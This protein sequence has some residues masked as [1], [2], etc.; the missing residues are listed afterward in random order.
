MYDMTQYILNGQKQVNADGLLSFLTPLPAFTNTL[1]PLDYPVIA[2][3]YAH[4][5]LTASGRVF[6]RETQ[7]EYLL[8]RAT[9]EITRA[10]PSKQFHATSLLVATWSKIGY[11]S[12][13]NQGADK[14]GTN[15]LYFTNH[16]DDFKHHFYTQYFF[17]FS[18]PQYRCTQ[19]NTFQ[20]VIASNDS[21]SF[22]E[23][24][25]A[26]DGI[27]WIQGI[28]NPQTGLPEAK[29]QS[30]LVALNG[31]TYLLPGSGTDQIRNLMR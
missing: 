5:D 3:L 24:L 8:S 2:A 18:P 20:V 14:V 29:A 26:D 10:F 1:L 9:A 17:L 6:Y 27:Q 21:E 7:N 11:Y 12:Y 16:L 13:N 4:A 19:T 25:Y 31:R 23:L 22:I 28:G 30:G 15:S